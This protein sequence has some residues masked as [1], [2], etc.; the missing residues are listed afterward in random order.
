VLTGQIG[1]TPNVR[2]CGG[3]SD[4]LLLPTSYRVRTIT[5]GIGANTNYGVPSIYVVEFSTQ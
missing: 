5:P 2:S 3:L 1:T 4:L